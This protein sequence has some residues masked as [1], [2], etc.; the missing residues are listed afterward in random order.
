M[1]IKIYEKSKDSRLGTMFE[2]RVCLV[3]RNIFIANVKKKGRLPDNIRGIK[4]LTCSRQCAREYNGLRE[5]DR[6]KLREL[7]IKYEKT[8]NLIKIKD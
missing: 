6:K 3:C 5:I 4:R 8:L 2:E 1:V 7:I